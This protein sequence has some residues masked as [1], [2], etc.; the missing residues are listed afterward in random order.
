M[1]KVEPYKQKALCKLLS[2][3]TYYY[4]GAF[5]HNVKSMLNKNI[6]GILGGTQC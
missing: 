2:W 3:R 1:V 6:G 5:T 4:H